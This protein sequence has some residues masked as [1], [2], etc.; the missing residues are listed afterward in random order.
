MFDGGDGLAG[1]ADGVTQFAL[2]H[3]MLFAQFADAVGDR[4]FSGHRLESA[5]VEDDLKYIFRELA[6]HQAGES[7]VE[8]QVA[9]VENQVQTQ[10]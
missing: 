10:R 7:P 6:E 5:P 8:E 1:D 3:G 4:E 2:C 9:I